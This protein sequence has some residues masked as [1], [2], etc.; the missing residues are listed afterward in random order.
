MH[1]RGRCEKCE[2]DWHLIALW[3][4]GKIREEKNEA[5]WS[6]GG[7]C[8]SLSQFPL[9]VVHLVLFP[10][11]LV[12]SVKILSGHNFRHSKTHISLDVPRLIFW[13]RDLSP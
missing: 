13:T 5:V 4:W 11:L 3:G 7:G 12:L 10:S 2:K 1:E 8:L 9:R 6:S